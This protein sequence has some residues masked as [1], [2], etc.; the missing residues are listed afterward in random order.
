MKSSDFKNLLLNLQGFFAELQLDT[1]SK[2]VETLI[3]LFDQ[4]PNSTVKVLAKRISDVECNHIDK[5]TNG[6]DFV[7]E[8]L[9]AAEKFLGTWA[10]PA[11]KADLKLTIDAL[12][13]AKVQS[14]ASL[15]ENL[16]VKAKPKKKQKPLREDLI[17]HFCARLE[18]A[19]GD[20]NGFKNVFRDIAEH[21]SLTAT[22]IKVISKR[23]ALK[24]PK[25][26]PIALKNI[27][28]RHSNLVTSRA[29]SAA[30]AGRVAG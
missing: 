29:K 2:G 25:S 18:D 30:T 23:F 13:M 8:P 7:I 21:K 11:A 14:V 22:E 1:Y 4:S 20:D 17:D 27:W 19:L 10:K 24:T 6:I 3:P 16:K 26:K 5:P 28:D 9:I 15:I 12:R